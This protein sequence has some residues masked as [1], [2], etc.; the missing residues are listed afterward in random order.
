MAPLSVQ[1][2]SGG[3][4]TGAGERS[5]RARRRGPFAATPPERMTLRAA[6]PFTARPV[7][8]T[9]PPTTASWKPAAIAATGATASR[10][11]RPTAVLRPLKLKSL[12]WPRQARGQTGGAT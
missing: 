8:V 1:R 5:A 4:Q 11:A 10:A 12:L 9:S 6:D 7:F 2:A 3:A